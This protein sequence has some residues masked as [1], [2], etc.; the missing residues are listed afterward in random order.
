MSGSSSSSSGSPARTPS[1]SARSSPTSTSR[2]P[3]ARARRT[4]RANWRSAGCG[5]A[6]IVSPTRISFGPVGG[7]SPELA[8]VRK[9]EASWPMMRRLASCGNGQSRSSVPTPGLQVHDGDLPP[10]RH[11]RR[12]CRGHPAAVDHHGRRVEVH[13]QLV[14]PA[15][16]DRRDRS[17]LRGRGLAE[18]LGDVGR[19][20]ERL[21]RL[22]DGH[23][24]GPGG[25]G[26][27]TDAVGLGE[28]RGDG[29]RRATS[30]RLPAIR[31]TSWS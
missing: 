14:E 31:R 9:S 26:E 2:G 17:G 7:L 3:P 18:E 8:V 23:R 13:E 6:Y 16:E 15:H 29:A 4:S 22:V 25:D 1:E 10:E 19:H 30:G 27:R 24:V 21:E 12:D 20:P 5:F 11:L 28:R